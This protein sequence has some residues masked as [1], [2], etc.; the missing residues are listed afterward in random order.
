LLL[1]AAYY[2]SCF[3]IFWSKGLYQKFNVAHII[4]CYPILFYFIPH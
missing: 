3:K 2:N 4:I 1:V